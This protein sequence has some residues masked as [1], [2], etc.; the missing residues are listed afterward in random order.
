MLDTFFLIS[1]LV[2]YVGS[3]FFFWDLIVVVVWIL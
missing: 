1:F 3:F 2:N